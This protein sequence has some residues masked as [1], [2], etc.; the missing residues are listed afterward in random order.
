MNIQAPPLMRELPR[1]G[2]K[3]RWRDPRRARAWGWG[4]AFGL[5]PFEVVGII[6]R[7]DQ[8]LATGLVLR[9]RLGDQEVSEVWLAPDGG[10]PPDQTIPAG[11]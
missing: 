3:V 2:Q 1:P 5:G 4:A 7:S 6:N 10:C 11:P 9:T 8:G